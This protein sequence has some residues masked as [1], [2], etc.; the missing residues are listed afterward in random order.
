[1]SRNSALEKLLPPAKQPDIFRHHKGH[2]ARDDGPLQLKQAKQDQEPKGHKGDHGSSDSFAESLKAQRS[3]ALALNQQAGNKNDSGGRTRGAKSGAQG[4]AKGQKRSYQKQPSGKAPKPKERNYRN[5]KTY[6]KGTGLTPQLKAIGLVTKAAETVVKFDRA[7]TG[8][9]TAHHLTEAANYIARNGKMEVEDQDGLPLTRE[10]MRERMAQWA[11][12]QDMPATDEDLTGKRA[13][14]AR[15]LILS[16][17]AGT[18]P[19]KV[20]QTARQFAKEMLKDDGFDYIM[21]LHVKDADHPNEPDH[22]HVHILI[23]AINK[24][25]QRLNPRKDDLKFMRERFATLARRN[26]IAMNATARAVRGQS[27]RSKPIERVKQEQRY[28]EELKQRQTAPPKAEPEAKAQA[29]PRAQTSEPSSA[30]TQAQKWAIHRKKEELKAKSS[31]V[32]TSGE[33]KAAQ[34]EAKAVPEAKAKTIPE[35]KAKPEAQAQPKAHPYQQARDEQV[36]KAIK[37][38]K[39]LD[40]HIALTKAKHTRKQVQA[41]AAQVVSEL[42]QS[43]NPAEQALAAGLKKHFEDL[44]PVQSAQERRYNEVKSFIAAKKREAKERQAK[45]QARKQAQ[46]QAPQQPTSSA[47]KTQGPASTGHKSKPQSQAQKHA[48]NR[49]KQQL[50]QQAKAEARRKS[51][52]DMER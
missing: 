35:N 51:S 1:M 8:V 37:E 50:A 4:S 17:P 52:P 2:I 9:K 7:S 16:C 46:A 25:G 5:A 39:P 43:T 3:S 49:K 20:W 15:R 36:I 23:K 19:E 18:E 24:N 28:F 10:E 14:D 29:E 34:P 6:Q 45:E 42:V 22:P 12:D 44:P 41:N 21:A 38:G 26:G 40:E 47:Q 48:I 33:E 30:Q 31:E 32:K 27:E 13:A 11:A